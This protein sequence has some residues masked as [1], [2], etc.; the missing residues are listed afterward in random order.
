MQARNS[1][2]V[3]SDGTAIAVYAWLP[4]RAPKAVIQIA[5]GLAE[6]AGRYARLAAD[7]NAV[8]YAVYANDHRGHGLTAAAQADLGLL[9]LRDGWR[10]CISDLHEFNCRI[11]ANHPGVPVI[12]LGHS[13]GATLALQFI[14]DHGDSLAGVVLSGASGQPTPMAAAGR[15]IARMER[16]RLGSQ[17]HSRIVHALTFGAFNKPFAP[18]RTEFDWLSRDSAEVDKYVAD[19]WCGFP[20]SV[21]LWIDLLDGWTAASSLASF[22]RIPK[23]LPVYVISGKDDLVSAGCKQL[24]P[25]LK[26][27]EAAGLQDVQHKFYSGARHEIFNETNRDEVT[28]DLITWLDRVAPANKNS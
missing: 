27:L 21:Q 19:P 17:G 3:A 14:S 28:R 23:D 15:L 26:A 2:M 16:L 5:H 20:C 8:G 13:M 1:T 6:H 4:V 12:L 7:L 18:A 11:A 25:M 10:K 24:E 22:R 9:A